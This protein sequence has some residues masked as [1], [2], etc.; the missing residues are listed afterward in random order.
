MGSCPGVARWTVVIL[1]ITLQLLLLASGV[2]SSTCSTVRHI[3]WER[4]PLDCSMYYM[5]HLGRKMG[6]SR[7]CPNGDVWSDSKQ[8]CVVLSSKFN[9]CKCIDRTP[10][11][12]CVKF[13][14]TGMF[15]IEYRP[16]RDDC[17]TYHVCYRGVSVNVLK[18]PEGL[19]W[20]KTEGRC[21]LHSRCRNRGERPPTTSI[22]TTPRP[23]KPSTRRTT[24]TTTRETVSP[25]LAPTLTATTETPTE[26]STPIPTTTTTSDS[27]TETIP[28]LSGKSKHRL[29]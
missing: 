29:V 17:S 26:P 6:S 13:P 8:R 16:D 24:T 18:C 11:S 4:H 28:L 1:A 21:S 10:F 23:T 14:C 19:R 15:L 27:V 5:C 22:F 7:R 9:D 20:S 25:T 3:G 2:Q 12:V